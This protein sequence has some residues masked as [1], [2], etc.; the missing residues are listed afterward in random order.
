TGTGVPYYPTGLPP[1][2]DLVLD[3]NHHIAADLDQDGDVDQSDFGILQRCLN[4]I[5]P[6]DPNCTN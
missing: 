5:E 3:S 1:D 6:A 4:G 2:C